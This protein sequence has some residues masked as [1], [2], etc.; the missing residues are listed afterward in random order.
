MSDVFNRMDISNKKELD[1]K[2]IE[3][4][5][6]PEVDGYMFIS[7]NVRDSENDIHFIPFFEDRATLLALYIELRKVFFN[8]LKR[9]PDGSELI[10]LVHKKL[11]D[12]TEDDVDE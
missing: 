5:S 8:F 1:E 2:V 6:D 10:R 4:I 12:I 9:F 3:K 11:K 7:L